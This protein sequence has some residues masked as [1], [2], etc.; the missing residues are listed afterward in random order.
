[1]VLVP[2]TRFP[3]PCASLPMSLE[4]AVV[5]VSLSGPHMSWVY[6]WVFPVTRS[7]NPWKAT[8]PYPMVST[9]W[10]AYERE[11][12]GCLWGGLRVGGSTFGGGS[13]GGLG[14]ILGGTAGGILGGAWESV[15]CFRLGSCTV[16]RVCLVG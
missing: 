2:L 1:M 11:S 7:S 8:T 12:R 15:L 6:P 3:T 5:Q 13:G 9:V 14:G 4:K 10:L 16:V